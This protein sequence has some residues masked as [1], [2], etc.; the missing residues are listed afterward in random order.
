MFL[1]HKDHKNEGFIPATDLEKSVFLSFQR[2]YIF[3]VVETLQLGISL[4]WG[5]QLYA[6][7]S[8]SRF[9]HEADEPLK[10]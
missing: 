4:L 8:P 6:F 10:L 5:R 7:T 1:N 3:Q 9:D 2:G